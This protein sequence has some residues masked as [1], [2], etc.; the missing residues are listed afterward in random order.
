MKVQETKTGKLLQT[1]IENGFDV[2]I[3][4]MYSNEYNQDYCYLSLNVDSAENRL[5]ELWELAKGFEIIL[6]KNA[7]TGNHLFEVRK[8]RRFADLIE[9]DGINYNTL[10]KRETMPLNDCTILRSDEWSRFYQNN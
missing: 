10:N 6:R 3:Y 7:I 5:N 1:L 2:K 8:E 4:N 9:Q